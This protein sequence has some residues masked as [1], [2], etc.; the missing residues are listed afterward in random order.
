MNQ[1]A[2]TILTAYLTKRP[3]GRVRVRKVG[4]DDYLVAIDD[5]RDGRTQ[6]IHSAGDLRWWL[7]SFLHGEC[8]VPCAAICGR[9]DKLHM[10]RDADGEF[11]SNCIHC[12]GALIAAGANAFL[13]QPDG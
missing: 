1:R 7:D 13:K 9:C 6:L 3:L 12:A 11:L 10:D 5:I 2:V 4:D 8:L